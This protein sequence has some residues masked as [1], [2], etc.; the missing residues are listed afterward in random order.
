MITLVDA[1]YRNGAGPLFLRRRESL[2]ESRLSLGRNGV[3]FPTLICRFVSEDC[4]IF[5][6]FAG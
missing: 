3:R 1:L 2:P 5:I 6:I 4:G